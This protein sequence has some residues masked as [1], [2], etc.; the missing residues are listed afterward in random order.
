MSVRV[1]SQYQA[2]VSSDLKTINLREA[3]AKSNAR[4][5]EL[6]EKSKEVFTMMKEKMDA[7]DAKIKEQQEVIDSMTV[8][9]EELERTLQE[10]KN[11][12]DETLKVLKEREDAVS[13][14]EAELQK[15][16]VEAS[17][18]WKK[19][20]E[21]I[22][23]QKEELESK[24][25]ELEER[26][27]QAEDISVKSEKLQALIN[28]VKEMEEKDGVL[29]RLSTKFTENREMSKMVQSLNVLRDQKDQLESLIKKTS[30]SIDLRSALNMFL[31]DIQPSR[32]GISTGSE[33]F[34]ILC[35]L[36]DTLNEMV[37]TEPD[38]EKIDM[39]KNSFVIQIKSVRVQPKQSPEPPARDQLVTLKV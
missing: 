34:G 2:P 21:E 11:G 20:D 15:Q 35:T 37:A 24:E 19:K 27:R 1:V 28:Q 18:D 12:E 8:K 32:I 14:R 10:L 29:Q 39:Y 31:A 36:Y 25:I 30:Q 23:R 17:D 22:T 3:L 38:Q 4:Y 26:E 13:F 16:I 5:T 9:T 7:S 33:M 6:K